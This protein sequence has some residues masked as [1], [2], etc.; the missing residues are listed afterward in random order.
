M[1]CPL[2]TDLHGEV[3]EACFVLLAQICTEKLGVFCPL[4]TDLH[5]EVRGMCSGRQGRSLQREVG[6]N[7]FVVSPYAFTEKLEENV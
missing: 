1:F 7:C 5:G 4:G 2:G 6:K 3:T